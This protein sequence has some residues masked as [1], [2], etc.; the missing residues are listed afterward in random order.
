MRIL[1]KTYR[2]NYKSFLRKGLKPI[3]KRDKLIGWD[4]RL[5]FGYQTF[6]SKHSTCHASS[7][8][9]GRAGDLGWVDNPASNHIAKS[10]VQ[11][12]ITIVLAWVGDYLI[13]HHAIVNPRIGT[14][15]FD[16]GG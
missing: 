9:K 16:R 10:V 4:R 7:V 3:N 5:V 2:G 8:L 6:G 14:N 13:N 1:K 12:I 15:L 11:S